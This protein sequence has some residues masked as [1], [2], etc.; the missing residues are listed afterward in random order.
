MVIALVFG[1]AAWPGTGW[2][3]EA[4]VAGHISAI[5]GDSWN[6]VLERGGKNLPLQYWANVF[7][8]DTIVVTGPGRVEIAPYGPVVTQANSPVTIKAPRKATLVQTIGEKF[9]WLLTEFSDQAGRTATLRSMESKNIP[10]NRPLTIPLLVEPVSQSIVAGTRQFTLAWTGGIS[11]F[12]A[13]LGSQALS[14]VAGDAQRASAVLRL[15][16]GRYE[17]TVTD[18]AHSSRSGKFDVVPQPPGIDETGLADE[19]DDVRFV[20]SALRL[21]KIDGGRWRLEAFLRLTDAAPGNRV[22]RLLSERLA[23]GKSLDDPGK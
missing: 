10:I 20:M 15:D 23:A 8:G 1:L 2:A 11:P 4:V 18:A 14:A 6:C 13:A 17:A 22:A 9:R 21:A 3:G 19:P 7:D 16:V 5:E 12:T